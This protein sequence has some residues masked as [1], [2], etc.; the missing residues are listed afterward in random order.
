[1]NEQYDLD[2]LDSEHLVRFASMAFDQG[3]VIDA[4]WILRHAEGRFPD[5]PDV[6]LGLADVLLADVGPHASAQ[7]RRAAALSFGDPWRLT[8]AAEQLLEIGDLVASAALV[9]DAAALLPEEFEHAAQ[10]A[11]LIG[12]LAEADG[13]D[14]SA[15]EMFEAALDCE[16]ANPRFCGTLVRFLA[17]RGRAQRAAEIL[18]ARWWPCVRASRLAT[19]VDLDAPAGP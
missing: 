4:E 1:M 13:D 9:V 8:R 11:H 17:E 2:D 7:V 18:A 6:Q 16:P 12:R 10:L 19:R 3:N 14:A 5:D 15:Q